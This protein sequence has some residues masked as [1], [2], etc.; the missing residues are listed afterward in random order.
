M[1]RKRESDCPEAPL[2]LGQLDIGRDV[3]PGFD[4]IT[5]ATYLEGAVTQKS[6]GK[7]WWDS[8]TLA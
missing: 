1:A 7:L 6:S 3:P 4:G 5:E 2:S 8:G